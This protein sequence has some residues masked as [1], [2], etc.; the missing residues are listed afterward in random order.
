[1]PAQQL[2]FFLLDDIVKTTEV[3][4]FQDVDFVFSGM[5]NK[6]AFDVEM[7]FAKAGIP[8]F[9]N[10]GSH[11]ANDHVPCVAVMSNPEHMLQMIPMQVTFHFSIYQQNSCFFSYLGFLLFC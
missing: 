8:V 6:P 5:D 9:S 2:F 1:M 11:R 10:A 4:N 3:E 7:N